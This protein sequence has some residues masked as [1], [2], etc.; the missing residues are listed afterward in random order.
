MTKSVHLLHNANKKVQ[1]FE[2]FAHSVLVTYELMT[3][4][5]GLNC[6]QN[7]EIGSVGF[8]KFLPKEID[9]KVKV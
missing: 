7:E 3:P 1:A 9:A 2:L 4:K 8:Y 6:F 5:L